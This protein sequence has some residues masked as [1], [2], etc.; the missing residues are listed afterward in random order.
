VEDR[1]IASYW[2]VVFTGVCVCDAVLSSVV[3]ETSNG[4]NSEPR[5]S[6]ETATESPK[7]GVIQAFFLTL[8][9][10]RG[11]DAARV[12][13]ACFRRTGRVFERCLKYRQVQNSASECESD[14]SMRQSKE[15]KGRDCKGCLAWSVDDGVSNTQQV[16]SSLAQAPSVPGILSAG[17]N[18]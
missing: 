11:S 6:P 10:F 8:L 15:E 5:L 7:S 17:L 3:V 14:R 13:E 12:P 2:I 4:Q 18:K 1:E 9:L 16:S